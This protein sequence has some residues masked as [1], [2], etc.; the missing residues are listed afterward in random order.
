[1][2]DTGNW[3]QWSKKVILAVDWLESISYVKQEIS[4]GLSANIIREAPEFPDR[5]PLEP[6]FEK[7]LYDF[8]DKAF[9][10]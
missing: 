7:A 1:V 2:V 6:N 5:H 4:V 10:E 8:Y 9:H 3:M